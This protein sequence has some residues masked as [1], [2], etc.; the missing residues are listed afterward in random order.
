M[1]ILE[2]AALGKLCYARKG[3]GFVNDFVFPNLH[4]YSNVI[5]LIN[6]LQQIYYNKEKVGNWEYTWE[7]WAEKHWQIFNNLEKQMKDFPN[8]KKKNRIIPVKRR[9]R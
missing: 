1:L 5:D 2:A 8:F 3:V 6:I 9:K 4:T 7:Q